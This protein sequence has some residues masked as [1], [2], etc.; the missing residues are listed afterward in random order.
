MAENIN[1]SHLEREYAK[2]H[3]ASF[4]FSECGEYL[5]IYE[6][7]SSCIQGSAHAFETAISKSF[8]ITYARP[9]TDNQGL[10]TLSDRWTRALDERIRSLHNA[11]VGTGRNILVAH[12]D[13]YELNATIE[14]KGKRAGSFI[15]EW[16]IP[17][18]N[19]NTIPMLRELLDS[20]T[21]FCEE[22]KDHLRSRITSAQIKL[23]P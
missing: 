19:R 14:V 3:F 1:Q 21:A 4:G 5:D 18:V 10:G 2:Y 23:G 8:V 20:A 11:L 7:N 15:F 12:M 6:K 22:K 17:M 13:V 9:F 16:P